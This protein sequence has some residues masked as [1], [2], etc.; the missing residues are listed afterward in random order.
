MKRKSRPA[1]SR[2]IQSARR[3]AALTSGALPRLLSPGGHLGPR[4]QS[5]ISI[6]LLCASALI[7][8]PKVDSLTY[9]YDSSRLGANLKETVLKKSNVNAA[10]FGKLAF[11]N[12]DGNIY[13]QPLLVTQ[14]ATANHGTL[15]LVIVATEH[16][17]VYAFDAN[18]ISPDPATGLTQKALWQRGPDTAPDGSPGLGTSIQTLDL[19]GRL[20]VNGCADTT[21]EVGITSTPVIQLAQATAPKRGVIF[22]VA[23]S[24][25]GAA[26]TNN[27]F[28]LNLADGKPLGPGT[29]IQATIMG[30]NG[31]IA[32]DSLH[33]F[34]RPALLLDQ[35]VLYIL[36]GGHCDKGDYRG[37]VFAYDVSNASAPKQLDAI[38]T[39]FTPRTD[40]DTD[41]NG[42]GGIWMSGYGPASDGINVYMVTG[43]GTYNTANPSFLELSDSVLKTK[44]VS[45]K[46]QWQDWFSPQNRDQ[47]KTFDVD[48]GSGGAVIV[49]NSHLLL[50]AGK[51]GRM[52]LIDRNDM[53]KGAKASLQSFQVTR[54]PANRNPN[55]Q[56]AGDIAFWNIHGTPVIWPQQGQMFVYVM[57][58]EDA[59]K[60]YKLVPDPTNGWRFDAAFKK[61]SK[62]TVGLPAPDKINDPNHQIF[63]PGGFLTVSSN[64]TDAATGIV[65][66]TMPFKDNANMAVVQ[67]ALRAFDASDVT[68]GELWDSEASGKDN[69]GF[70]AKFNPPVVANGKVLVC[71]FQ[72]ERID[73][74]EHF[75]A[76][77]GLQPAL[78]IY[79][80]K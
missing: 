47:L 53:G 23:K 72:Q 66:A 28:A 55:P 39:T 54:A 22:V 2:R 51:E 49:P 67:G 16:N 31:T 15:D 36:F 11:R 9:R 17:S 70:F 19:Y 6:T 71:A 42:R 65:W 1:S 74:G 62:E 69:L 78:V 34:N 41:K 61:V 75:V 12:V 7:A 48:L 25:D 37:W 56:Q 63:M 46:F 32:F 68:K 60:Q 38:T 14:A 79:G 20:G 8:Q 5:L 44:L 77:G 73:N 27:L 40:N 4:T 43:D 10:K 58:E 24:V 18:D 64:G 52:Y 50:A 45:G 30:P 33:E 29:P 35:N 26:V 3:A 80:L 13:A 21:T 59:L 76:N 57:G